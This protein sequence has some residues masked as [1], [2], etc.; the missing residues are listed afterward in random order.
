MVPSSVVR[1]PVARGAT[2]PTE[3][4]DRLKVVDDDVPDSLEEFLKAV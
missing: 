2:R 4:E 3:G 1:R